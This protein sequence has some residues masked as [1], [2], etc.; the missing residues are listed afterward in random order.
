MDVLISEQGQTIDE[1][2][3]QANIGTSSLRRG[4]Q[5]KAYRQ[6]LNVLPIRGNMNTRINKLQQNPELNGVILAKTGLVRSSFE[7]N[8]TQKC[9]L[10]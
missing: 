7:D 5:I 10:I 1:L 4:S 6:D 9:L 2:P 3:E 8:I